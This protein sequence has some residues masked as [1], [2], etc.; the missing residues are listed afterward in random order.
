[1]SKKDGRVKDNP[2]AE[3][4]DFSKTLFGKYF[5]YG[6]E[7]NGKI[8]NISLPSPIPS[9]RFGGFSIIFDGYSDDLN[10]CLLTSKN[11]HITVTKLN[12]GWVGW[13]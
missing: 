1:M 7:Q 2:K 11:K 13:S 12:F 5:S 8:L 9:C 6:H 3:C 10:H 4:K